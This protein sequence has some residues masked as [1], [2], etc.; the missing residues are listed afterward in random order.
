MAWP[1]ALRGWI[2]ILLHA[3]SA[4]PCIFSFGMLG[5]GKTYRMRTQHSEVPYSFQ[6]STGGKQVSMSLQLCGKKIN[7]WWKSWR[8]R[9]PLTFAAGNAE[10]LLTIA[11]EAKIQ[12]QIAGPGKERARRKTQFCCL[13]CYHS[14]SIKGPGPRLGLQGDNNPHYAKK[15]WWRWI[16]SRHQYC[17][18][19]S[20]PK[21]SS[22][23]IV[24]AIT[25]SG[26]FL[27]VYDD[28]CILVHVHHHH[29]T[30]QMT[31]A[32]CADNL[33]ANKTSGSPRFRL[34]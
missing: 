26:S 5:Q 15:W 22:S 34:Q 20:T 9:S 25:G 7:P 24:I 6:T 17:C 18:F 21:R 16:D 3:R 4:P 29:N 32:L 2:W 14:G 19:P 12:R 28:C 10:V 27:P 1:M 23:R 31:T 11:R 13:A 33:Q 30:L 8:Y